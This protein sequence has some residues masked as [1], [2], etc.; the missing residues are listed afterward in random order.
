MIIIARDTVWPGQTPTQSTGAP[1][2]LLAP[3]RPYLTVH[4]TGAGVW[5]DPD[6]TPSELRAIQNYAQSAG[7]GWEYNWV[8]DGQGVIWEYAGQYQ[9]AHSAGENDVAIGVLLLVGFKGIYPNHVEY[10]EVPTPPMIQAVRELRA[11]LVATHALAGSHEMR[12][13]NQMPGAIT[14]CP[15]PQVV[16]HWAELTAP[17]EEDDDMAAVFYSN[18]EP[19]AFAG[20]TYPP[21]Q[22][23]YLL[24]DTGRCRRISGEELADRGHGSVDLGFGIPKPNSLLDVIEINP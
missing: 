17:I 8:I 11:W 9:A 19:R 13:H 15:G 20:D 2:P 10:W 21:R 14:P 3:D 23:K 16:A 4:Y 5:L 1:R 24:L 12:Q 18:S 7:K 22:I 6:D